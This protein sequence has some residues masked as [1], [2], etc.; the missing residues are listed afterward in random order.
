MELNALVAAQ[1]RE[2]ARALASRG[3]P[4][5]P[6][7]DPRRNPHPGNIEWFSLN[8]HCLGFTSWVGVG[9][10]R[11]TSR[12][13]YTSGFAELGSNQGIQFHPIDQENNPRGDTN[14][15]SDVTCPKFSIKIS[16]LS[17]NHDIL[18]FQSLFL[19]FGLIKEKNAYIYT[20][21]HHCIW[22]VFDWPTIA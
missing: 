9:L 17:K 3:V 2:T 1:L 18:V 5:A 6:D 11:D 7:T 8:C 15:R 16:K 22:R 14:V 10:D 20:N 13:K 4:V 21:V 19:D 12:G